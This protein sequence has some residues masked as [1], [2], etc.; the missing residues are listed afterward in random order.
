MLTNLRVENFKSIRELDMNFSDLNILVG[1]NSSGKTS[2]LQTLALLKQ[3][4]DFLNFNGDLVNLGKFKDAVYNHNQKRIRIN[5]EFYLKDMIVYRDS[6]I[7][8]IHC[9]LALEE[10]RRTGKPVLQILKVYGGFRFRP[11]SKN[12]ILSYQRTSRGGQEFQTGLDNVNYTIAGFFPKAEGGSVKNIEEYNRLYEAVTGEF[13]NFLDYLSALRGI[14]F[15]TEPID[16]KYAKRFNDVGPHGEKTI[17]VL[18]HIRDEDEY[19]EVMNKINF[20]ARQ[21]GL[22]Q[23]IGKLVEGDQ[24]S[25]SLKVRN[26]KTKIQS[27]IIDVGFGANQLLPII[28]QCYYAEKGSLIMI[29]QPEAHLHPKYQADVADLLIDVV[30]YGNRVLVETHSEH[31]ILR[32]QRRIAENKIKPE[33]INV[34]YFELTPNGT[35][36]TKMKFNDKGFFDQPIPD[37]FFEEGFQEAIAHLKAGHPES[38]K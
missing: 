16:S 31:L 28:V 26:A 14:T 18:A 33:R 12:E 29:E 36:V 37:G 24:P 7:R 10:N 8:K 23:V 6:E 35:K 13:S 5:F 19:K 32:L 27:N 15:R 34:Y 11:T 1:P 4:V 38:S 21:F 9:L 3:S 2:V 22:E 30:D 17:Q 25:F 20:W